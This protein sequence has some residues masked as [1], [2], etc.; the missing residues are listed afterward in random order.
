MVTFDDLARLSPTDI[1]LLARLVR[2][3]QWALAFAGTSA[4]LRNHILGCLAS[5]LS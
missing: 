1:Q 4:T 3:T 2:P 5:Q